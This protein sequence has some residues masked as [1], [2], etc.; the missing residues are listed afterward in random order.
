MPDAKPD[1]TLIPRRDHHRLVMQVLR[2]MDEQF[3]AQQQ[4]WFGDGTRIVLELEEYRESVDIDFLCSDTAGYRAIRET[5]NNVSFGALF[6]TQPELLREIRADR[7]GVRSWLNVDGKPI[8]L[9]IVSEGRIE[10]SGTRIDKLP[11]PVLDWSS[12]L[13]EKLLA[14][15]DRGRDTAHRSR[16]VI[17]LAYMMADTPEADL[18]GA[19]NTAEN[20]YGTS[21]LRELEFALN[22]LQELHYRER[23]SA[24]LQLEFPERLSMGLD[25][26]ASFCELLSVNKN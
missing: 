16:D 7:Y 14:N 8:K 24:S 21:V 2:T 22:T 5:V 17:D 23:C 15:T 11:V 4:C 25:R 12:C 20:A 9:E 3:L 19:L 13:A 18:Q 10:L 6:S 1:T 26:L